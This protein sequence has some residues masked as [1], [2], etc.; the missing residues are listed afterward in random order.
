M[1]LKLVSSGRSLFG[2]GTS[3]DQYVDEAG[4]EWTSIGGREP[5][6]TRTAEQVARRERLR[7]LGEALRRRNDRNSPNQEVDDDAHR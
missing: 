3:I 1:I 2:S 7:R 4:N 6:I 5:V